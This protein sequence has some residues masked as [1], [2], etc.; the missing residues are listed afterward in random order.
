[1][2]GAEAL[3]R[4]EDELWIAT[5]PLP[6]WVGDVGTRMSVLRLAGSDLLIHSPVSIDP[7]L[8]AALDAIG[9]VRWVVGPSLVHHLFLGDYARAYPAAEL[10]GAPGLAAKRPDLRFHRV[11]DGARA[12][13]WDGHLAYR[14]FEGAPRLNEVVFW[15]RA[16]RTLLLTD[17]AF[18]VQAGARNRAKLF[19]WLVGAGGR[20]GPHR[21]IRAAIRDRDA[22]R[23]SLAKILEWDF[24][25]VIVAH[26]D[27]LE[28]GGREALRAAFAFLGPV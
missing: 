14:L 22:A 1:M 17:L 6:L 21:I 28:H 19:H 23:R 3:E 27:V 11:L 5:R 18:N 8:R 7:T 16:T 2:P 24:D 13:E 10:W 12:A 15:Q 4:L 26:G 25:R 20:F 9:R